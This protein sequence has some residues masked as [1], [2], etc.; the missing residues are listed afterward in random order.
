[1]YSRHVKQTCADSDKFNFPTFRC[2][3]LHSNNSTVIYLLNWILKNNECD[4]FVLESNWYCDPQKSSRFWHAWCIE[5]IPTWNSMYSNHVRKFWNNSKICRKA[6]YTYIYFFAVFE[7][8]HMTARIRN[9]AFQ[10]AIFSSDCFWN[11]GKWLIEMVALF[12]FADTQIARCLSI[13]HFTGVRSK[14]FHSNSFDF[15]SKSR[16]VAIKYNYLLKK[17][18]HWQQ[19]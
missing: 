13:T 5:P 14:I 6:T 10:K 18:I 9:A 12:L 7:P 11:F 2:S 1:M 19:L 15:Q 16:T 17:K 4:R 3:L 8:S